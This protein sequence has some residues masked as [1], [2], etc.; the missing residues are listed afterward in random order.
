MQF[1]DLMSRTQYQRAMADM[2]AAGLNPILAYKQGGAG[3]PSGASYT[4]G[5]VGAGAVQ[6]GASAATTGLTAK[7]QKHEI[8]N[9]KADTVK[10][11]AE[12]GTV[13]NVGARTAQQ[14]RI[15]KIEEQIAKENLHSARASASQARATER[16]YE[17]P[18]GRKLRYLDL[19]GK[20][21]NPFAAPVSA[22]ASA[23][24]ARK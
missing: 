10:K 5:N 20:S 4:A 13:D 21:L 1:Q 22:G 17:T 23:Y 7:R 12:A 18:V 3:T 11:Q 16:F 6:A 14:Y 9:I 8:E 24:R 19:V 15:G 2:K